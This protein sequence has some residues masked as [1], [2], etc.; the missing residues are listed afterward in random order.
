[1][2]K[3]L[4]EPI[5]KLPIIKQIYNKLGDI[6]FDK[7]IKLEEAMFVK[8]GYTETEDIKLIFGI[9]SWD[10][11]N[12]CDVNLYTMNDLDIIYDKNSKKYLV[13]IESCYQWDNKDDTIIY[14]QSLLLEFTQYMNDNQLN[15]N[16]QISFYNIFNGSIGLDCTSDSI[17]ECYSKFKFMVD[18]YCRML[19]G[20]EV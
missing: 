4:L 7:A 6:R 20:K 18:G 14:L 19:K 16:Y 2:R 1:M 13:S 5:F 15:T 12:S 3:K 17:E 10:C 9:K 8:Y 11:L